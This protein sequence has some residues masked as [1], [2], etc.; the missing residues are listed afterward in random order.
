ML[1]EAI[2]VPGI[3]PVFIFING[4]INQH[5]PLVSTDCSGMLLESK[6]K[7][8]VRIPVVCYYYMWKVKSFLSL[9]RFL[10]EHTDKFPVAPASLLHFGQRALFWHSYQ[11]MYYEK[12][13]EGL[14]NVH[15][16]HQAILF[17]FFN[18]FKSAFL[19]LHLK[20]KT[21]KQR[22]E[23]SLLS[24]RAPSCTTQQPQISFNPSLISL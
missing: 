11:Q 10:H 18:P 12:S 3:W 16:V 23:D 2:M 14:K 6:D 5:F 13:S 22:G 15:S 20:W 4:G 1:W 19:G 17:C 8:Q 7:L 24:H 21:R 9:L